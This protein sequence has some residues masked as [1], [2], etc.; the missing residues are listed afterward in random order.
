MDEV[1]ERKLGLSAA[2]DLELAEFQ[3]SS[4][5]FGDTMVPYIE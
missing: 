3:V 2:K 5:L 1:L 4:I